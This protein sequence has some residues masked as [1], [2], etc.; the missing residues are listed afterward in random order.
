[1]GWS[2]SPFRPPEKRGRGRVEFV[3]LEPS[4]T[5][6]T[7]VLPRL[8][9]RRTSLVADTTE[10]TNLAAFLSRA[11]APSAVTLARAH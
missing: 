8:C 10:A 2:Q 7:P 3:L 6:P 5:W 11:R 1:M 4:G 9:A